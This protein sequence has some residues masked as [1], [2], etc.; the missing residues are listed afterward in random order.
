ML[1]NVQGIIQ[2]GIQVEIVQMGCFFSS[3]LGQ[4]EQEIAVQAHLAGVMTR[5]AK[6]W[7]KREIHTKSI[8][9]SIY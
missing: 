4:S 5:A 8:F 7:Q 6:S 1:R 2:A 3:R 9:K